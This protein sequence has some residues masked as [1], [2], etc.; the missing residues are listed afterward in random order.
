MASS[1]TWSSG[2]PTG[3]F[4]GPQA[5]TSVRRLRSSG[6]V[7]S[8]GVTVQP[9][10]EWTLGAQ[11]P[12]R[13]CWKVW[14]VPLTPQPSLVGQEHLPST[15][16]ATELPERETARLT[17]AQ[18]TSHRNLTQLWLKV[19]QGIEPGS[20]EPQA[21]ESLCAAMMPSAHARDGG[22]RGRQTRRYLQRRPSSPEDDLCRRGPGH[23]AG[24]PT[25]ETH[26]DTVDT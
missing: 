15:C 1:G 13:S 22:E 5:S 9:W 16:A 7:A 20:S 26:L 24:V 18:H 11:P 8:P 6:P 21:G 2:R 4:L 3:L 10:R 14:Q 17:L 23:R 19:V 12:L 25:R